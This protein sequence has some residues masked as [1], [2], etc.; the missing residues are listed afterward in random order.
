MPVRNSI[1]IYDLAR[2]LKQ[3]T[4]RLIEE[5]QREGADVSVASNSV[6][7]ELAEKIRNKYLLEIEVTPK[8]AIKVVRRDKP[9]VEIKIDSTDIND[10]L[11]PN[12]YSTSASEYSP[13]LDN[14]WIAL[15]TSWKFTYKEVYD[16]DRFLNFFDWSLQD[17]K[18]VIDFRPCRYANYQA[19]SLL[20][21]YM[22]HLERNRCDVGICFG[23]KGSQSITTMWENMGAQ[24][25]FDVLNSLTENFPKKPQKPLIAIREKSDLTPALE[26]VE[27]YTK[28]FHIE[29]EKT[30]R[31]IISELIYNTI[32]HGK[33]NQIPSLLQFSWYRDKRE[34]SFIVADLG[35]GIREHLSQAYPGLESDVEAINLALEPQVSGTSGNNGQPYQ[36]INNAGVG[37]YI[38][39]NIAKRLRA[40]MY[41]ISKKGLVHISPTEKT[42]RTLKAN[43][44]GT[45]VYVTL[46]INP[47]A[48]F[49]EE[50]MV[51]ELSKTA[52]AEM[53]QADSKERNQSLYLNIKNYFG[54]FAEDKYLA[55]K[56]RDQKLLPAIE[57]GKTLKIDFEEVELAPHSLLNAL[58]ATPVKRLGNS[59]YIKIKIVNASQEIRDII[60]FIFADNSGIN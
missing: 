54:R 48:N 7:K 35:I 41:V 50:N 28:D 29:Y 2:E 53:L 34:L 51:A 38:S 52:A 25:W 39:S 55:I 27:K 43:W 20:V 45:F 3:D 23:K 56:L 24:D 21:L 46:K 36:V 15:P 31:Y 33:N 18:V 17:K 4:K 1:R 14:H 5:L 16:F 22:W 37:L 40:D 60:E 9:F 59:A 49:N 8:R 12:P 6:S 32:E 19:V 58:L 30:L 10:I 11:L 42:S 47:T 13:S 57:D 44:N 26:I